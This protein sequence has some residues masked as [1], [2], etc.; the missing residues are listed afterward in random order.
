MIKFLR[1]IFG[2]CL[3]AVVINGFW[4][5]FTDNFGPLGGWLSALIFTG[6]MWFVNHYIGL[7]DNTEEAIFIDMGLAVGMSTLFRDT[8]VNG[9]SALISSLP[10]LIFTVI[11]G[12]LAGIV[13][14]LVKK[15][16]E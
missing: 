5:V 12:A 8:I 15:E 10:T 3:S 11:G 9:I 16:G 6:T 1:S 2:F 7:V 4:H 14:G 13:V